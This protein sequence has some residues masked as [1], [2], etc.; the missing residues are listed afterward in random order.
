[1]GPRWSGALIALLLVSCGGELE[2]A[3]PDPPP[4]PVPAVATMPVGDT[5]PQGTVRVA[6]PEAVTQWLP[7]WGSPAV[8]GDLAALWGLPLYHVDAAGQPRPALVARAEVDPT[9]REVSLV[10][11]EGRWSDGEEVGAQDLVATVTALQEEDAPE[12][13]GVREVVA[14]GAREARVVFEEPTRTWPDL[15][16]RLGVLPGHVLADG[17]LGAAATLEVTGGPFRLEAH[18]EGL[19]SRFV[20]HPD[21]PLG[22]PGLEAVE[23]VVVPSF[24]T[25]L[26]LLRDG[27]LDAAM[28]HL[29]VRPQERVDALG[30]VATGL[31]VVA[32][33]G[34]T[35]LALAW[36]DGS[37]LDADQRAAAAGNLSLAAQVE[38][39]DLGT[40]LTTPVPGTPEAELDTE[41]TD[42]STL[43]SMDASLV[44]Q[45]EQ[46][47][48]S[49]AGSLVEAQVRGQDGRVRVER[50]PS[51]ED[52]ERAGEYDGRLTVRRDGPFTSLTS[53][54]PRSLADEVV[55]AD[56][57]VSMLDPDS[58]AA[59]E[60]TEQHGWQVPL[61]RPRV[62]HVWRS[63]LEGV[64]ASSWPSA[65]FMSAAR[66]RWSDT[67]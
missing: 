34:G 40:T 62:T 14:D 32:P 20:A 11:R 26:G 25:A 12:V 58:V 13:A 7:R 37:G 8:A 55:V 63:D 15:L 48:L 29:A 43:G 18:E 21:G 60:R 23:A 1:M 39:L 57:T 22:P 27:E 54:V 38:A 61:Y 28:G 59:F 33:F 30:E 66:W 19:T 50:L 42:A 49:L 9:G 10:L 67:D 44:L 16:G 46:E 17:G 45:R 47:L 4:E 65:G 53:W 3:A 52:V 36:R 51:P 6:V 41:H 2:A 5:D 24:D 31:E 35:T 64:A 56:R